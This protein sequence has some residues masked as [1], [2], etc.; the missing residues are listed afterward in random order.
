MNKQKYPNNSK[1]IIDDPE[2]K[3]AFT[4]SAGK[5]IVKIFYSQWGKSRYFQQGGL[6]E[7]NNNAIVFRIQNLDRHTFRCAFLIDTSHNRLIVCW[8]DIDNKK[9][10]GIY[11]PGNQRKVSVHDSCGSRDMFSLIED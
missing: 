5:K 8:D 9:M 6:I 4:D 3:K 10:S 11:Y 2:F 7:R 1:W